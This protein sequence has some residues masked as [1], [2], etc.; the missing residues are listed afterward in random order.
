[1]K[2]RTPLLGAAFMLIMLALALHLETRGAA[3]QPVPGILPL[4]ESRPMPEGLLNRQTARAGAAQ[5]PLLHLQAGSFV[6]GPE[7]PGSVQA[8]QVVPAAADVSGMY[9]VQFAGSVGD[10]ERAALRALGGQVLA[11]MPDHA[12]KV[13]LTAMQAAAAAALPGVRW[14]G[15]FLPKYKITSGQP[16][17]ETA[18]YRVQIE[19]GGSVLSA[20]AT[21]LSS[22]ATLLRNSGERLLV[23][24]DAQ[25]VAALASMPDVG[26]LERFTPFEKQNEFAGGIIQAP[27]AHTYAYDGRTQIVAVTD[28]GLGDGTAAGAHP[29]LPAERIVAVYNWPGPLTG[30]CRVG[31]G[32]V[33]DGARDIDGH[34]TH[35]SGSVLGDGGAAGE[36]R[37]TAPGARLIFQ[38]VENYIN[39]QG[40]KDVY[41]KRNKYV[42]AVGL[43][44][45]IRDLFQQS[46]DAGARIHS[47]SWG[48]SNFG[49]YSSS[50]SEA[51]GFIWNNPDM[52]ITFAAGNDGQD[53]DNDGVVDIESIIDP[54]TAK[55]V[56]TVGASENDRADAYRCDPGLPYISSDSYQAGQTCA[57]MS[58]ANL[59]GTGARWGFT[60]EPLQSDPTAGNA[61][62]IAPFSSRGPTNDGRIKPDVVAPGTWVL[63]TYSNLFQQG[64]DAEPEPRTSRFQFDGWGLP[65]NAFY[66]YMGGTSMSTPLVAGGAAVVRDYYQQEYALG[67]SAALVKA[68]LVNSAVDLL[69]ENNDGVD[70]NAFPVPNLHEGWGLVDLA[71][72]TDGSHNFIDVMDSQAGL[73]TGT[74]Y[75]FDD[76]VVS[77]A[78]PLKV[79]L[80][81]S[82]YPGNPISGGYLVNVLALQVLGPNGESYWGNNFSGGWSQEGGDYD[83]TNNV[84]NVFVQTPAAGLWEVRVYGIYVPAATQT[85]ALVVDDGGVA[86]GRGVVSGQVDLQGR[87]DAPAAAVTLANLD[88]SFPEV[89]AVAAADGTFT[90]PG[91]LIS[92]GGSTYR[93]TAAHSL[94][95]GNALEA[96]LHAGTNVA[97]PTLLRGG[98]AN[99]DGTI[100]ILDLSCLGSSYLNGV[101]TCS[102]AGSTDLNGDGRTNILDLGL[103]G[104]NYGLFTW[105]PW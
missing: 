45:D 56:L 66:K 84:Q 80:A 92:P 58:G 40:C 31:N 3:A 96:T 29:D 46:Y 11:Y 77:G 27:A 5:G 2:K 95:V 101:G 7:T 68:T 76:L 87:V 12:F 23:A 14:V 6:P 49:Y 74:Y 9:V 94:Y 91:I 10:D 17:A 42:F 86:P 69:D 15:A 28:T 44:D 25:Q 4:P 67:A 62:Q 51:D 13:R 97:A 32:I 93:L 54:A 20:R 103:A 65:Y 57:D 19:E 36:G 60:A 88:G 41:G 53:L 83:T 78:G 55:N 26:L 71:A 63:S 35:V 64:Y 37:G 48:A 39:S 24:A 81:W 22:G 104:G 79:T 61:Q 50:S 21:I 18:V 47:N 30:T 43:P 38:A 72:A 99:N 100:N 16:A 102:A 59:L 73:T 1:M 8:G 52:T 34:G 85:F 82:D 98:D 33:D 90:I 75:P 105:Q 89:T 70:D